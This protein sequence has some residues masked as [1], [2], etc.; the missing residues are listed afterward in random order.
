MTTALPIHDLSLRTT[1]DYIRRS[2]RHE[3]TWWQ[4]ARS[5][6][7]IKEQCELT[8]THGTIRQTL[9]AMAFDREV[10]TVYGARRGRVVTLFKAR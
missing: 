6:S 8:R 2:I 3:P 7:E 1:K 4:S 9:D 5:V 10:V